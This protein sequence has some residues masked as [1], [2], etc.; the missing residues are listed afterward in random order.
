MLRRSR[1][2]AIGATAAAIA[3]AL[4]GCASGAQPPPSP[5]ASPRPSTPTATVS[6]T[7]TAVTTPVRL[8]KGTA[9]FRVGGSLKRKLTLSRGSSGAYQPAP[10][11]PFVASQTA[12]PSALQVGTNPLAAVATVTS[13]TAGHLDPSALESTRQN[14][15]YLPGVALPPTVRVRRAADL[16][17]CAHD[18]VCLAVPARSLPANPTQR[19]AGCGTSVTSGGLF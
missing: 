3:L 8:R 1:R 19:T 17:L 18:L 13:L 5:S 6:P 11:S 2:A 7:G 4:S 15:A 9:T 10:G 16:E 12:G 14:A